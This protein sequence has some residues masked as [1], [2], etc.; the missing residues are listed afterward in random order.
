MDRRELCE[1]G[2][3]KEK[4][5]GS[6]ERWRERVLELPAGGMTAQERRGALRKVTGAW[7]MGSVWLT[8][9]SGTPLTNFGKC[10]GMSEFQF[11]VLAALPFVASLISL[12]ASLLTEA[13][14]KRKTIFLIGSY[15]QR[16]M[17]GP[18][19][20]VPAAMV[21]KGGEAG[22][23]AAVG[24]FL[25]LMF[26]MYGGGA[27]GGP[28]WLSWMADVVPQ[29]VRGKYFAR[30]RQWGLITAI[31][32]A[33]IVGWALDRFTS[34]GTDWVMLKWCA[35][36]FVVAAVFG[37]GDIATF[38]WVPEIPRCGQSG[39]G[40][41]EAMKRPLRDRNFINFAGFVG[42]LVFAM[43]FMGQFVTLY[44]IE[45]LAGGGSGGSSSTRVNTIT[46]MMLIIAPSVAQLLVF[47]VWGKA[48]DR[49]GKRPVLILAGLGLVPVG[50]GWC[51]VTRQMVWL[52]YVLSALGAALW[53]GVEVANLNLVLEMAGG[54]EALGEGRGSGY[55][56]VNSVIVS[57][58][59]C[60]GGLAAGVIAQVLKDY[61]WKWVTAFKTFTFY[62]VLFVLSGLMRLGAVI[63]FVPRVREN[64]ARS[65]QEALRYMSV[66]IYNNVVDM[67]TQPLKLMGLG[68]EEAEER[69]ELRRAG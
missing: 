2:G 43:S 24:A 30:R 62:D 40:L 59:G 33:L 17:W 29:R 18:I 52:G 8:A 69:P 68:K 60:L 13:T 23:A 25:I 10:L 55:V 58:A 57:I 36:I 26:V 32:T 21:W 42:M 38:H 31:P 3:A 11:G 16:V 7:V 50:L 20:L 12:P 22:K 35:G 49:M 5:A 9:F 61:D 27:V 37:V 47:G 44:I 1:G 6:E 15:L 54:D 67:A 56:A 4:V 41:M 34:G 65:T 63:L 64:Q 45:Q 39:D 19:A 28:G 46:Q 14:G 66:D 48:V 51:F 53:A